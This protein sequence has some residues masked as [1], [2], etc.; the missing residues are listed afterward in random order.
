V[1]LAWTIV[2][3]IVVGLVFGLAPGWKMSGENLQEALKDSGPGTSNGRKH[4]TL[5][6]VLVISEVALACMLVVGAGLLLRSFLHVLDVDLGF[7]PA[8]ASAINVEYSVGV[9]GNKNPSIE[10][11]NAVM[12]SMQQKISGIA[13]VEAAGF[14]D[15]LP[16]LRNRSWG[17][18]I[19]KGRHYEPGT[20]GSAFVYMISPGYL[21]A[22]GMRLRGR[23]F[24]WADNT[25]GE[26]VLMVNETQAQAMWPGQDAVGRMAS[27]NGRDFRVIGVIDNVHGTSVEGDPGRQTY[28]PLTQWGGDGNQLVVQSKLPP[29]ALASTLMQTLREFNPGQPAVQLIPMQGVVDRATS[30]RRFFAVLVGIF[31]GLGLLLASLGIYGVISYSVTRQT[32]E[33]G[34]RMALGATRERVQ[35]GVISKTLRM[36]LIG[37]AVGTAFSLLF[38]GAIRSMLFET[39]ALDPLIFAG[40]I[41]LLTF[42]AFVAGYLPARRA[43]RIE[44]M[45]A[46]RSN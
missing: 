26:Q 17:A 24:T 19:V 46:L 34:I 22:I 11:R 1:V 31:A 4:E 36:A 14:T 40:M 8:Q 33:I 30:P 27:L 2:A 6:S 16:L 39:Q 28:L 44:P 29:G 38:A 10:Q 3:A 13:G 7:Q 43:S 45:S 15:N 21:K 20:E 32:Q 23:D 18:P 12:Q 37:V 9:D 25:K 42:V 35:F 5:R 41:V